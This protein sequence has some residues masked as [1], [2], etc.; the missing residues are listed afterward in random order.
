MRLYCYCF[1]WPTQSS[2]WWR[3]IR[4]YWGKWPAC[5][6]GWGLW[7]NRNNPQLYILT[8][9]MM[10]INRK[11]FGHP[12]L[13]DNNI[14]SNS[15]HH[16][17]E[18]HCRAN[19]IRFKSHELATIEVS[20]TNWTIH[21]YRHDWLCTFAFVFIIPLSTLEYE[22]RCEPMASRPGETLVPNIQ[23]CVNRTGMDFVWQDTTLAC[24][25]IQ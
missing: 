12:D 16:I 17:F 1:R 8:D 24:K 14:T 10:L 19:S 22:I 13:K 3:Q 9:H 7:R 20:R 18:S 2:L 11:I 25:S 21:L 5:C 23:K 6:S 15:S 4:L